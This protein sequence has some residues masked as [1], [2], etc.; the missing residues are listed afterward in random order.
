MELKL[1]NLSNFSGSKNIGKRLGRGI[2]SGKGKTSG[3]G[4]KGQKAR[5]G[6]S[7][8]WFEG[9]QTS[10][11]KRLFK[12]GFNNPNKVIFQEITL[13]SLNKFIESGVIKSETLINSATLAELRLIKNSNQ[14]VKLLGAEKLITPLVFSLD[15]YSNN[16]LKAIESSSSSIQE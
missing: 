15:A 9:G 1:N 8:R 14:P 2:G 10:I 3:R 6:V 13:S 12:R 5:S 7:I 16:A 4:V 11:V